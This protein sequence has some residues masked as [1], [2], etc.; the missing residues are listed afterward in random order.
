MG[1][2]AM[3][4]FFTLLT[5]LILISC[6]LCATTDTFTTPGTTP[7]VAP[8]GVT[9]VDA[10]CWGAGGGGG[11]NPTNA[12]GGGGAGGGAYARN[13]VVDVTPTTSYN[14]VV[15]AKG[16][17]Q[18][19]LDGTDGGNSSFV[20]DASET[21]LACGGGK[22]FA[23]VAGAGGVGGAGG[24]TACSTGA[25]A[26]FAGGNGG[27]GRDHTAGTGGG[28]GSSAGT[29]ANGGNGGNGGASPGTA[30]SPPAG[31]GIGGVGGATDAHGNAP[32]SGNGGGGGGSGSD[33][34]ASDRA[35]G[36]GTDGKCTLTYTAPGGIRRLVLLNVGTAFLP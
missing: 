13:S 14:V 23:P 25:T 8:A 31:G 1:Q 6:P 22:G 15:G 11:G 9:S 5:L 19:G 33:E 20:G 26:E 17:G 36:D 21:V 18:I 16:I 7:W 10:E 4:R 29:G 12:D 3:R 28:G 27:T 30:G 2:G 32:V 24:T 35:G 34:S